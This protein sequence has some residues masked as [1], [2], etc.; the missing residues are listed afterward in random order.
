MSQKQDWNIW[1]KVGDNSLGNRGKKDG[2]PTHYQPADMYVGP[3]DRKGYVILKV[4]ATEEAVREL[5]KMPQGNSLAFKHGRRTNYYLDFEKIYNVDE[6]RAFRN[7]DREVEPIPGA[8]SLFSDYRNNKARLDKPFIHGSISSGTYT[9][10]PTADYTNLRTFEGDIVGD[11]EGN[12]ITGQVIGDNDIGGGGAVLIS[13]HSTD[14]DG[15]IIITS[16]NVNGGKECPR[17]TCAS[18][19]GTIIRISDGNQSVTYEGNVF[20]KVIIESNADTTKVREVLIRR[21]WGDNIDTGGNNTKLRFNYAQPVN[22]VLK[23]HDI[24]MATNHNGNSELIDMDFAGY[25]TAQ[26]AA[27]MLLENITVIIIGASD[28]TYYVYWRNAD[29]GQSPELRNWVIHNTAGNKSM[30]I[31]GSATL[32]LK[33]FAMNTY[34]F[35][36]PAAGYNYDPARIATVD[37]DFESVT[38]AD[39]DFCKIDLFSNLY[40]VGTDQI[41][42]IL[43]IIGAAWPPTAPSI[44]AFSGYVT[45]PVAIPEYPEVYH[46]NP[47]AD[48][49]AVITVT[50]TDGGDEYAAINLAREASWAAWKAA[51]TADQTLHID[52]GAA[53]TASRLLLAGGFLDLDGAP[54]LFQSSSDDAAWTDVAA[55]IQDGAGNILIGFAE[56][57]KRYWRVIM[58]GLTSAP[59]IGHWGIYDPLTAVRTLGDGSDYHRAK[60]LSVNHLSENGRVQVHEA[61]QLMLGRL[62]LGQGLYESDFDDKTK[63]LRLQG[64]TGKVWI[65]LHPNTAPEEVFNALLGEIVYPVKGTTIAPVINYKE[66]I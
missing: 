25:T 63:I 40:A 44:G 46:T 5:F 56:T 33:N 27:G 11:V 45:P 55:W 61:R 28:F 15:R 21:V 7:H 36:V 31:L 17:I 34:P 32:Q 23:C 2:E 20:S 62:L 43:D 3:G 9:I 30:Y 42:P 19:P 13:D 8:L 51:D 22:T 14:S 59:I 4:T 48:S 37:G 35:N 65:C 47:V 58:S 24:V 64:K 57:T 26:Y 52:C 29:S 60:D 18:A 10:G 16:N 6:V 1:F 53:I 12:T 50:G 39:D 49:G 66:V 38:P 54:M 41:E